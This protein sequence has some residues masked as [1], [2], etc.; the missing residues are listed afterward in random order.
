[1]NT[2]PKR[3]Q[4]PPFAILNLSDVFLSQEMFKF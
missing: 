4:N 1:M 2:Q 3:S